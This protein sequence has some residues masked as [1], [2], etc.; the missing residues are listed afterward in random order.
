MIYVL[1]PVFNRLDMTKHVLDCLSKQKVSQKIEVVVIDDGSTDGTHEFLRGQSDVV[2][3]KGDGN[4]WWGGA[5]NLGL[6]YVS[7]KIQ[8]SDSILFLNNDVH[9]EENYLQSIL[10]CAEE[11]DRTIVGSVIKSMPDA[12]SLSHGVKLNFSNCEFEDLLGLPVVSREFLNEVDVLSGRGVLIPAK[13]IFDVKSI[14]TKWM[15]HYLG[16]YDFFMRL[17]KRGWRLLVSSSCVVFSRTGFGSQKVRLQGVRRY[18][19][20]NSPLFFT[21]HMSF[22]WAACSPLQKILLLPRLL[23]SAVARRKL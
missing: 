21:A 6:E 2:T 22:W 9:L 20:S 19:S 15:P 4:L 11:C 13:A 5:I 8:E 17:K 3:L 12:K 18:T 10:N 1:I 16:D 23:L 14:R 7:N